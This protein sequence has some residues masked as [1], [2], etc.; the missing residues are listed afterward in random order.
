[1][2]ISHLHK[3]PLI[4]DSPYFSLANPA[5]LRSPTPIIVHRTGKNQ[6]SI[7][8]IFGDFAKMDDV[9]QANFLLQLLSYSSF[10]PDYIKMADTLEIQL[11]AA[12]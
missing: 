10:E 3:I 11:P 4:S 1:M 6:K 9:K 8:E 2:S 5:F 12:M 7:L